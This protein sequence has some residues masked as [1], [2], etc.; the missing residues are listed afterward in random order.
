MAKAKRVYVCREC[1]AQT[2]QWAGRCADCGA[3]NSLEE[4]VQSGVK[5]SATLNKHTGYAGQQQNT[6]QAL[7][8][9]TSEQAVRWSTG[10]P[11]LDRV[12][13]GG[14]VTGSVVLIGGDPGIGKSTLLL[15]AMA[16]MAELRGINPLYIS[17]EESLQQIRL[18]A[19]RLQL[20]ETPVDLL[21]ETHAEQM[22]A[23]AQQR[24]PQVMV[25]D[26]IQTVFT[27]LLQSAPGTVAQVRESAAQLVRFAKSSGIT[28][29]L[30]GHVTKQGAL[31]G[32]RVLEHMVDTVLYF[33]G[34]SSTRFRILRAVKN[35]FGA[36]NE[37]GVFAMTELGLKEV[38][39]PSAIFLSRGEQAVPGSM[40]TVI[41]EGSR[42]MLVEVQALVDESP[43]GNPR[44][45]SVG[46]EQNRLAMLLAILHR[47]GGITCHDQDVFINV[48][49]GV[50]LSETGAD[51][52]VL[53]AVISSLRN[54]AIPQDW[55]VF[56]E[57]GLTGEIRPV[58]AGE[59]RI[60]DAG[61]HG[62]KVALVPAAN[63]PRKSI[64]GLKVIAVHHLQ[65]AIEALKEGWQ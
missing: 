24:Q 39:N 30:V 29:I 26:S 65:Q 40:I 3:W 31:A 13:G 22:M 25:I 61:K 45:V 18:R 23:I 53:T 55:V 4:S 46:L 42:P 20:Q 19:E 58:Q 34:D 36:V 10:L 12:L 15:Q 64:S 21:A 28:M 38:S 6:V 49:G 32:P 8:T 47:H 56:G 50:K 7:K 52:A 16:S 11:E 33:E 9:I 59:E 51:L 1:G 60:R 5:P 2:P 43:L 17:G 41:R 44:R 63:A 37:L 54:K 27:E 57:V 14:L 62:F 35:R 48:V